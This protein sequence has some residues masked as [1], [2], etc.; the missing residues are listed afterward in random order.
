LS[1]RIGRQVPI[2]AGM[3]LC[4][5]GVGAMPLGAGTLWWSIWALVTGIGMALLYP[6]L[7]AAVAD[8]TPPS[9]RGSAL[10]VYRFWRDLGYGFGGLALGVI[11]Q[12]SG[13]LDAAFWFVAASMIASGI[14][15]A[16]VGAESHGRV[17]RSRAPIG[18]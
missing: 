13:A 15:F 6:T 12:L 7:G 11:A 1:D 8:M 9:W 3:I 17:A 10:G 5:I 16:V 4:G 2:V 14:L 18:V